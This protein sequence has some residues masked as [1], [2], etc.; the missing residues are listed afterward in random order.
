MEQKKQKIGELPLDLTI[1]SVFK[2]EEH[3]IEEWIKHHKLEGVDNFILLNN[4]STDNSPLIAKNMGCKVIDAPLNFKQEYYLNLYACGRVSSKIKSKWIMLIDIDEFVYARNGY[5]KI[6]DYLN[7]LSSKVDSVRLT[8]KQFGSSNDVFIKNSVIDSFV[9]RAPD[10][11]VLPPP[12]NWNFKTIF[13]NKPVGRRWPGN[14]VPRHLWTHSPEHLGPAIYPVKYDANNPTKSRISGGRGYCPKCLNFSES[15]KYLNLNHYGIM[16]KEHFYEYRSKKGDV[17]IENRA[18]GFRDRKFF[19][20]RD[21]RSVLD[22]ELKIKRSADLKLELKNLK[23]VY[24]KAQSVNST[25]DVFFFW[26]GGIQRMPE[27]LQ[28]LFIHNKLLCE[29]YGLKVHLINNESI[30]EYL[31]PHDYFFKLQ[32]NHQSDYVRWHILNKY[33][34]VWMDTDIL[35]LKDLNSVFD[36][37]NAKEDIDIVANTELSFNEPEMDLIG[38][39]GQVMLSTDV[40][41]CESDK[42]YVKP[43]CCVIFG[44]KGSPTIQ[45]AIQ[46]MEKELSKYN[47]GA[48]TRE[49]KLPYDKMQWHR[50]GPLVFAEAL[51][52]FKN[53]VWLQDK[54]KEDDHGFQAVTWKVDKLKHQGIK[55]SPGY[56]KHQWFNDEKLIINKAHKILDNPNCY[57]IPTWSIYRQNDIEENIYDIMLGESEESDKSLYKHLMKGS[58]F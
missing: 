4:N 3:V 2:D 5:E 44:K 36:L 17:N 21:Y 42:K 27:L 11:Q 31:E 19:N 57:Y 41:E 30:N 53:R 39:K 35:I 15:E 8:F 38:D 29:R 12:Q 25:K 46:Q 22:D 18:A 32:S 20:D 13:R 56:I 54:G 37:L 1:I 52:A 43:G 26:D 6:T 51:R 28:N 45:F 24:D 47:F 34:G 49:N 50:I 16:S 7:S 55:N 10:N 9:K 33:G 58:K 48:Y 14:D 40:Q 23:S